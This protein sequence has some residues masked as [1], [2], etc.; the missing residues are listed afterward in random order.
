M[1]FYTGGGVYPEVLFEVARHW[2][3]LFKKHQ[4]QVNT[5]AAAAAAAAAAVAA[6]GGPM[7]VEDQPP[8]TGGD[9]AAVNQ[10]PQ[11]LALQQDQPP[12]P[13]HN[14]LLSV[15]S[16]MAATAQVTSSNFPP[17]TASHSHLQVRIG[18]GHTHEYFQYFLTTFEN[19]KEF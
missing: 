13:P 12:P 15:S 18:K 19:K 3:D 9:A 11:L 10:P 2:Y 1:F 7:G 8:P 5:A 16:A 4:P 17:V 14:V 6:P